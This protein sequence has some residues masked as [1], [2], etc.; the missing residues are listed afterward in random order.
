MKRHLRPAAGLL[1]VAVVA[2]PAGAQGPSRK[3]G[4]LLKRVPE[5]ANA[6]LLVDVD[7]LLN[8]PLGQREKWRERAANRPT[9][10]LGV[11]TDASKFVVAAGVDLDSADERW[12][13]GMLQTHA[14]PPALT[15]LASREG[16]Y[17]EQLQTQNVAWT[18]RNFYLFSFPER[19]VGFAA[20]ADRQ[21]LSG[22]VRDFLAR[23]RTFPQSWADR[24]INRADAG[25]PIVL[26]VDLDQ[27]FAPK[28]V[29][30]WLRAFQS[31]AV[32]RNKINFD[33]LATRLAGA[34]SAFLQVDVKET[35]D[36]A[37]RI[38]FEYPIDMIR[39]I[40]KELVLAAL[41]DYGASVEDLNRWTADAKGDTITLSGRLSEDSVRRVLGFISA[42]RLSPARESYGDAP[43]PS[44][45]DTA[46][47]TPSSPTGEP[48]R[49]AALKATQQYYRSVID[50]VQTL[51]GHKADPQ[52]SLK[53]WYDRAA[54]QI[55][56]LPLLDVDS[57]LLDWGSAMARNLREMASGINYAARDTNF[58][59]H[60]TAGGY[61]GGCS[62]NR[63]ADA[64]VIRKQYGDVL[65]VQLDGRWQAIETSIADMRR[66]LVEKYKVDF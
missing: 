1:I 65:G 44:P 55:E 38:E 59:I 20:P 5:H 66:K 23:P 28:Q 49:D 63:A 9:G 17:V 18:P 37:I 29:E 64:E 8:S 43:P 12:K 7:G 11:S 34:K 36:G 32:K 26:A 2:A 30:G 24:A 3:Y 60:G 62:G 46:K 40:A 15:A 45:G 52:R 27:A 48:S 13:I 56:G 4:E 58:R 6:M 21:L 14:S 47:A 51:K 41:E 16:G 25:S 22:W 61:Y 42:P 35:I 57:E 10:A 19:I 31:E 50:V 33:I 54:K 53:L 39:P